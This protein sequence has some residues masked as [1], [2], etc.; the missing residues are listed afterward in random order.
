MMILLLVTLLLSCSVFPASGFFG[1]DRVSSSP[2]LSLSACPSI[3][4]KVSSCPSGSYVPGYGS[5][6]NW[7]QGCLDSSVPGPGALFGWDLV[8][9]TLNV[10]ATGIVLVQQAVMNYSS[11]L[12]PL[13]GIMSVDTP[14]LLG[15]Y[16]PPLLPSDGLPYPYY[17][18][19]KGSLMMN[20]P[21]P[22]TVSGHLYLLNQDDTRIGCLQ[23]YLQTSTNEQERNIREMKETV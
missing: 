13:N 9:F 1:M 22:S 19:M 6:I 17:A 12:I 5:L 18:W 16:T 7:E 15:G 10:T 4:W 14:L 2:P 3:I 11:N 20:W 21:M 8:H 23:F